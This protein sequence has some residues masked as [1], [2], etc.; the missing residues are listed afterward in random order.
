MAQFP[1]V[2]N[3]LVNVAGLATLVLGAPRAD[4]VGEGILE[5]DVP[6]AGREVLEDLAVLVTVLEETLAEEEPRLGGSASMPKVGQPQLSA[7]CPK[8]SWHA[9]HT[10]AR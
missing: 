5:S 4:E 7:Q 2:A 9:P 10:K 3:S 8:A 6:A 1:A